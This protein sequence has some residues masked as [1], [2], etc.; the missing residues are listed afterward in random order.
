MKVGYLHVAD[1]TDLP[2]AGRGPIALLDRRVVHQ[3]IERFDDAEDRG[4]LDLTGEWESVAAL[5][6]S[7]EKARALARLAGAA[8]WYANSLRKEEE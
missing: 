1:E 4:C 7:P 6:D 5:E 3:A 8:L 2:F